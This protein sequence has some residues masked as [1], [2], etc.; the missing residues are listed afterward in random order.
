MVGQNLNSFLMHSFGV[1]LAGYGRGK[2]QEGRP[3]SDRA[4]VHDKA[5][6]ENRLL[7]NNMCFFFFTV[8]VF[9]PF[10]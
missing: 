6:M 5:A 8:P 2:S 3:G 7:L 4:R 9:G 10:R 1:L